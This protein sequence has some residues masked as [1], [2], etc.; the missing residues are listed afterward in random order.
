MAADHWSIQLGAFTQHAAAEKAAHVALSKVPMARGKT[1][2]I[3]A[4]EKTDKERLYRVR[5]VNFSKREA[6]QACSAL[7]RKHLKCALV[8]PSAV[9]LARS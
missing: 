9:K 1:L 7:H 2:Q 4:P 8:A 5:L 3:L 6:D